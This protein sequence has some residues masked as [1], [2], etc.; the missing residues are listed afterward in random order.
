MYRLLKNKILKKK[1]RKRKAMIRIELF[2]R[3]CLGCDEGGQR[4][5]QV[6]RISS[7]EKKGLSR[8]VKILSG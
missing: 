4:N 5:S 7:R 2:E 8:Q 1:E 3:K 6:N